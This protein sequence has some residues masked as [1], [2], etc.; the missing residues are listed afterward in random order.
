MQS[1]AHLTLH[2]NQGHAYSLSFAVYLP[3]DQP[4]LLAPDP[5]LHPAA[6]WIQWRTLPPQCVPPD[7]QPGSGSA[8]HS[9]YCR[10]DGTHAV[11]REIT[12]FWLA[13]MSIAGRK[14][15]NSLATIM[16]D[17]NHLKWLDD[18]GLSSTCK[19]GLR[20]SM[21]RSTES[22]LANSTLQ[23]G[24]GI[25]VTAVIGFFPSSGSLQRIFVPS[26]VKE[27]KTNKESC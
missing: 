19:P 11:N 18:R 5:F 26:H 16:T 27:R 6:L 17:N 2:I 14:N 20:G 23:W 9:C 24:A 4:S 12:E 10:L 13:I 25:V 15:N 22:A 1:Y 8:Q 7:W 21:K 3:R